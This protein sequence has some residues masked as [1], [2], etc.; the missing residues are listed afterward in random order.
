MPAKEDNSLKELQ[1]EIGRG[2]FGVYS[3]AKHGARTVVV[4]RPVDYATGKHE[5]RMIALSHQ[6]VACFIGI[7]ERENRVDIITTFYSVNGDT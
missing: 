7:M 6:N 4:K 2:C 3:L 5:A 1:T